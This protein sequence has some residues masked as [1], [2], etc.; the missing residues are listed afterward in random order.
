M[1]LYFP[2]SANSKTVRGDAAYVSAC[3]GY[4]VF[5]AS[6]SWWA[7]RYC[8]ANQCSKWELIDGPLPTRADAIAACQAEAGQV[9]PKRRRQDALNDKMH[10]CLVTRAER[11]IR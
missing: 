10:Q 6:S 1:K 11:A 3:G 2:N 8:P 5:E 9:K 7:H 4:R